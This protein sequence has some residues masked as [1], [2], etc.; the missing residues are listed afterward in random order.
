MS[1]K[2][3]VGVIENRFDPLEIGRCQV[4][5]FGVHTDD[6]QILPTA[7]LPWA[8]PMNA[9]NNAATS[10][11][12][13]SPNGAVQGS[14]VIGF[15]LDGDDMQQFMMM[16]TISSIQAANLTDTTAPAATVTSDAGIVSTVVTNVTTAVSGA[17]NAA[18]NFITGTT[19]VVVTPSKTDTKPVVVTPSKTDTKP[20][21][22]TVTGIVSSDTVRQP[23]GWVLG[24][25]SKHE[26][27]G[28]R[29]ASAINDYNGK[30]AVD[31]GGASYGTYQFA[32]FL[33][34]TLKNGKSR[35]SPVGCQLNTFV[36]NTKFSHRFSGLTP[37]TPEFDAAWLNC[38][39]DPEFAQE[40]HEF[41]KTRSYDVLLGDLKRAGLDLSK[42][43]AGVQDLVWSTAVQNG[44]HSI[45]IFLN[46]LKGLTQ[47][48]DVTIITKVMDYKSENIPSLFRK[49]PKL[50]DSIRA[51]Y[52]REKRDLLKLASTYNSAAVIP[53]TKDEAVTVIPPKA[54]T[55]IP[56]DPDLASVG[57]PVA[58]VTYPSNE[59]L[60]IKFDPKK[61]DVNRK[62]LLDTSTGF[63]D[64]D[65]IY[66]LK[67]YDNIP[68]TNKMARGII[69]GTAAEQKTMDRATGIRLPDSETFDQPVN[70]FNAKYP[71]NKVFESESGHVVEYDDTP[72]SERIN[73]YHTS[74][75]FTEIDAVGNMVRRV[76]GSDYQITD[77]NGYVRIEGKCNISV[78]GS[79][80][81][82]VS[83]DANI[84]V[85]GDVNLTC[86]NDIVAE[87]A[88]RVSISAGEAIDLRSK[89]IY[90]EADEEL[91]ITS[92]TK[93]NMES[94]GLMNVKTTNDINVQADG[95]INVKAM[96]NVNVQSDASINGKAGA[97]LNLQS[98]GSAN[99]Y[100]GG[101]A[102]LFGGGS[103]SVKSGGLVAMDG[104]TMQLQ[105]GQ[106]KTA[107]TSIAAGVSETA[108]FS[109]AGLLE[110]R[111]E[112]TEIEIDDEVPTLIIDRKAMEVET[113]EEAAN[114]GTE[115]AHKILIEQGVAT[116]SE[117]IKPPVAVPA[118]VPVV[119]PD[120]VPVPTPVAV[121]VAVPAPV[122]VV[123]STTPTKSSKVPETDQAKY[124][125]TL[126][127]IPVGYKLTPNFTLA[128]LSVNAPA[129]RDK[130]RAQVGLTEGEIVANMYEV[131]MN[132]L[133]PIKK[134]YP[135]M[136]VTSCFR[137]ITHN[138]VKG[139]SQHCLGLAADMQFTG[140]KKSDYYEIATQIR[141]LLPAYDQLLLEYKTSGSKNPWIHVSYNSN[142]N[143][144]QVLTFFNNRP[145]SQGLT[146]LA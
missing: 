143:R 79:C 102:K 54:P 135:N 24:Q 96:S 43:G 61:D 55:P 25:T 28:S 12:G 86:G 20:V 10:G 75:T 138:T 80:N 106:A 14:W 66:P 91:H 131:A 4:R 109:E 104:S 110:G 122:P 139:I 129:Q 97:D 74:G 69:S 127:G 145:H 26:E 142:K 64:P 90:I 6:K 22:N 130:V 89:N 65:G 112:Y 137:D 94:A 76:M 29:G 18:K 120:A 123:I 1:N 134:A 19:P 87:A 32:S 144:N 105:S 118:P 3:H 116:P 121:T 101:D 44:P 53:T 40:Q 63:S 36:R 111:T 8:M 39:S 30:S 81:I 82:V 70:P 132:V 33:P 71:Y 57:V 68:D 85:D 92:G 146:Q 78:G 51:R 113:P 140:A 9:M 108:Q 77:G 23:S 93:T 11:V 48:D 50:H 107:G 115:Q 103:A 83:A 7:D 59:Q 42:F 136:F 62:I 15:F 141:K 35:P 117:L 41:I 125:K 95:V 128:M 114:G 73:I 49:S 52:V 56:T 13:T 2:F 46:P 100:A 17:F 88:G 72:G 119:V 67:E 5:V 124:I 126:S 60:E 58:A 98:S 27:S 37:A 21:V 34:S 99:V 84:E 133:E 38:A 31:L 47:L 16:G 45:S